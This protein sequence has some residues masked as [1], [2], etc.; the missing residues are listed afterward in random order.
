MASSNPD[1]HPSNNLLQWLDT[2]E[3]H[4]RRL[5]GGANGKESA[6]QWWSHKRC[7]CDPW[8]RKIPLE[9][10][11]A[12]HS[13]I[14]AWRIPRTEDPVRLQSI[15]L[16]RVRHDWSDLARRVYLVLSEQAVEHVSLTKLSHW[17]KYFLK[18]LS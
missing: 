12:A 9:E 8:L 11:R 17:H 7:R 15:G 13:S 18:I 1:G 16:Q 4:Y 6:C 2:I 10:G 14:L 3:T 5:P